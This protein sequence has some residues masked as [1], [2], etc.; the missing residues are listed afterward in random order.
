M[1]YQLRDSEELV[2]FQGK[3]M[4]RLIAM[5]QKVTEL[6]RLGYFEWRSVGLRNRILIIHSSKSFRIIA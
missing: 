1:N 6:R 3:P 2:E 4:Y 5:L